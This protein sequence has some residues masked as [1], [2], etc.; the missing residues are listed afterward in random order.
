M[1]QIHTLKSNH[2]YEFMTEFGGVGVHLAELDGWIFL[3]KTRDTSRHSNTAPIILDNKIRFPNV[4]G[5][6]TT[7][8]SYCANKSSNQPS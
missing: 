8:M 2:T 5:N 6:M 4:H 1:D 7:E 3:R